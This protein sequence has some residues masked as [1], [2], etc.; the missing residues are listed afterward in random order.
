MTKVNSVRPKTSWSPAEEAEISRIQETAGCTRIQ[1]V[2][3]MKAAANNGVNHIAGRPSTDGEKS[4]NAKKKAEKREAKNKLALAK[5]D[6]EKQLKAARKAV[7]AEANAS[8][9]AIEALYKV[10]GDLD[11]QQE[12][13]Y[14]KFAEVVE[15][16]KPHFEIVQHFFA[17][18]K[19]DECLEGTYNTFAEWTKAV[20]NVDQSTLRRALNPPVRHPL[21]PAPT[22]STETDTN[23]TA[24][25]PTESPSDTD[26]EDEEAD[27]TE[28]PTPSAVA[29]PE[30]N[31]HSV[32]EMVQTTLGSVVSHYR[33]LTVDEKEEY[34]SQ[35]VD[36][37]QSELVFEVS[38][39]PEMA[40]A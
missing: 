15:S 3:K 13:L 21:L 32:Q 22:V 24:E 17:H 19:K 30:R 23:T 27:E 38:T 16:L 37:L 7:I 5:K 26:D 36:K 29:A 25:P 31:L 28:A 34:L 12:V 18:K 20:L 14:R 6:A 10:C 40:T 1:A 39:A 4:V 2:M 8:A 11:D 9:K 33:F 35:L